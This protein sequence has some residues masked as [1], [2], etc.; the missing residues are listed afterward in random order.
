[1]HKNVNMK[2]ERENFAVQLRKDKR[3]EAMRKRRNTNSQPDKAVTT[4]TPDPVTG[5]DYTK[6]SIDD[7]IQY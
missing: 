1:M 5:I 4:S 3:E 6:L 2:N 7:A